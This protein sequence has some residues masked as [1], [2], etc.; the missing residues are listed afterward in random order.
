MLES[1]LDRLAVIGGLVTNPECAI[2][3]D[4]SATGNIEQITCTQPWY[5]QIQLWDPNPHYLQINEIVIR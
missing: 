1:M 2:F 4:P 3:V 5:L